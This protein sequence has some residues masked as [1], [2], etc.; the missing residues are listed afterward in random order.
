MLTRQ[1]HGLRGARSRVDASSSNAR[2]LEAAGAGGT[3]TSASI[4]TFADNATQH[5]TPRARS[6]RETSAA[7]RRASRDP[8]DGRA[9]IRGLAET[10][11]RQRGTVNRRRYRLALHLSALARRISRPQ[12]REIELDRLERR[13]PHPLV[14]SVR[15]HNHPVPRL[16]PVHLQGLRRRVYQPS[17]RHSD[18]RV[19]GELP[20]SVHAT[21]GRGQNF[22]HPIGWQREVRFVWDARQA[23]RTPTREIRDQHVVSEVELGFIENSPAARSTVTESIRRHQDA[24]EARGNIGVPRCRS[25]TNHKLPI[26]ELAHDVLGQRHDVGVGS[27]PP[28]WQRH[29]RKIARRRSNARE[30]RTRP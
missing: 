21:R 13:G 30:R 3:A 29:H 15:G 20:S 7:P 12:A 11:S 24:A 17:V 22:A 4:E 5:A 14:A 16:E 23:V 25:R 1:R 18:V 6:D 10:G 8:R 19:D 9:S 26:H 28:R 27:W 2:K